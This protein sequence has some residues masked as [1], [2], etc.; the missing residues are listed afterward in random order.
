MNAAKPQRKTSGKYTSRNNV[1][2]GIK[3]QVEMID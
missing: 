3:V 2:S 1:D